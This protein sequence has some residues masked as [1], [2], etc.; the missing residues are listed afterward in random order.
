[1]L[2]K[3]DWTRRL[4]AC[5]LLPVVVAA[6]LVCKAYS[7][8]GRDIVNNWGPASVAYEWLL[9]L[10][11][12]I[13]I[14]RREFI[15]RIAIIVFLLTCAIEFLQ[16]YQPVW[17]QSVRATWLGRMILGTTFQWWDFPAY[18]V[19][20]VLGFYILSAICRITDTAPQPGSGRNI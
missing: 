7:G 8:P 17:L 19:G 1:M 3:A 4:I 16:L 5:G 14:P 13:V 10:L 6:G 11:L 15:K 18:L 2:H 20:C 12:F 9:M